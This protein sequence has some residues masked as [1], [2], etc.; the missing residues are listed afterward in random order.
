ESQPNGPISNLVGLHSNFTQKSP[1]I[2]FFS[3]SLRNSYFSRTLVIFNNHSTQKM[4]KDAIELQMDA[5]GFAKDK[6]DPQMLVNF[7]VLDEETELRKYVL[8]NGQDYLGFGPRS[9][10]VKMVP[11]DKGTVL[12]N[13]LDSRTGN[14]IW[15][16]YASGALKSTDIKNMSAMQEKVGAIF[17]DFN[18][19]QFETG[20]STE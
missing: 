14:Q 17:E 12:I 3:T 19:N 1:L 20:P 9:N 18:F 7:L 10:S 6:A 13:F 15:Q 16:G 4:I 5:R 2:K 11:V 8:D